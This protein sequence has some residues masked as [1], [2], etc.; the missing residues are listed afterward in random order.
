MYVEF[1]LVRDCTLPASNAPIS[2][3]LPHQEKT[4]VPGSRQQRHGYEINAADQ[5][6]KHSIGASADNQALETINSY[7]HLIHPTGRRKY[8]A[9]MGSDWLL[10]DNRCARFIARS[11]TTV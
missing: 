3:H 2:G 1:L 9:G 6:R 4:I 11:A 7:E 10:M 8:N 5:V